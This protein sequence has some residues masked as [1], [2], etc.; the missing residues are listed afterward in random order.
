MILYHGEILE[1]KEQERILNHL[2]EDC[3]HTLC[4]LN[5][6]QIHEVIHACDVLYQKAIHHEFDDVIL[7]ILKSTNVSYERFLDMAKLFSEEE[8]IYKCKVEWG[9]DYAH[10]QKLKNGTTRLRKPLGILFH[11]AAGNVDV[12][13]AFSVIE[14]LLAGN[15]NILKLPSGD[16]GLSVHLLAQ[17]IQVE[18]ALKDYIYVFDVPSTELQTLKKFADIADGIVVWGGDLAVKAAYQ[19]ASVTTKVIPWGHKLSF[20]YATLD[21]TDAQLEALA[22]HI[23][24]TNQILCSSC[25]GIFVDTEDNHLLAEFGYRFFQILKKVNQE[26]GKAD[27]GMRGKNTIQ[28]YTDQLEYPNRKIW[29][30]DGVSVTLLEDQELT[31]SYLFRNVW[32]KPLPHQ[33]L[34]LKLKK[35][36][37]HLQTCGLLC[38]DAQKEELA[39][40]ICASGVVRITS[41]DMSR[42]VSGEAHDGVY[43]LREYSRIVEIDE[44]MKE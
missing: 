4:Q 25:Q 20:A 40:V 8:L 21:A 32:I 28:L 10:M 12:L 33:Q 3:L 35:Y 34:I 29:C 7:P 9:E 38:S 36:K 2:E 11:I 43:P 13:P 16:S 44:T 30:E 18:P 1:N 17:L 24:Y 41:A 42:I 27:M 6:P 31:L 19:M 14:G 15:I 26:V 5:T 23:C 22:H 39:K 37:S